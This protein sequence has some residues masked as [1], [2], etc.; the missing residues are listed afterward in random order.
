MATDTTVVHM[1]RRK[2]QILLPLKHQC[3][4]EYNEMVQETVPSERLLIHT[5]E[6]GQGL[7]LKFLNDNTLEGVVYNT[8]CS[9]SRVSGCR[10]F[11]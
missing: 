10:K 6:D 4:I 11:G 8:S 1:N 7:L 3:F 9:S 2:L 5:V